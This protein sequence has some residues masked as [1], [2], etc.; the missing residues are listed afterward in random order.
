[1]IFCGDT[2]T[3]RRSRPSLLRGLGS[4]LDPMVRHRSSGGAAPLANVY[5]DRRGPCRT[6][7]LGHTCSEGFDG[8]I[9]PKASFPRGQGSRGDWSMTSDKSN[10]KSTKKLP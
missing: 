2:A 10:N 5:P 6:G 8:L 1:M 4:G 7:D 3:P 9:L